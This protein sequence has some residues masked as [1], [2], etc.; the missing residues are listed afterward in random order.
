MHHA[1]DTAP[2]F[3]NGTNLNAYTNNPLSGVAAL[4]RHPI[5]WTT[6]QAPQTQPINTPKKGIINKSRTWLV[7]LLYH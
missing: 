5:T 3:T 1:L 7:S 4:L 2:G 6:D